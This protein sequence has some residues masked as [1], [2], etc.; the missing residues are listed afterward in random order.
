MSKRP[1]EAK[2]NNTAK[3]VRS[4]EEDEDE[5]WDM[6]A[7]CDMQASLHCLQCAHREQVDEVPEEFVEDADEIVQDGGNWARPE[8]AQ[9]L[10]SKTTALGKFSSC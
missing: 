7:E 2:T 5:T 8:L 1:G 4:Q 6:E 3:R 10:D 9:P